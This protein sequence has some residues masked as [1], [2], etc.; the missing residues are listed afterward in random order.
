MEQQVVR[1]DIAMDHAMDMRFSKSQSRLPYEVESQR[2]RP[3][4]SGGAS[5]QQAL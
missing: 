3:E 5:M 1:L 4:L 2:E